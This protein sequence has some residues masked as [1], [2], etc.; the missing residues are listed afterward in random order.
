VFTGRF[1]PLAAIAETALYALLIR[2]SVNASLAWWLSVAGVFALRAF[3]L[4]RDWTIATIAPRN[5]PEAHNPRGP[6]LD[7]APS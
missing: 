5:S 2:T 1:Y 4:H 6:A 7:R 3:A